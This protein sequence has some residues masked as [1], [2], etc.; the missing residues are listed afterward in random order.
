MAQIDLGELREAVRENPRMQRLLHV[1]LAGGLSA[2]TI[3][4]VAGV[5]LTE[6]L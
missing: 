1:M 3:I 5:V 4:I 6:L 2:L